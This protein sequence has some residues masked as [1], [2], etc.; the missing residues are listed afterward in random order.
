MVAPLPAYCA[1]RAS[2]LR[3]NRLSSCSW[4]RWILDIPVICYGLRADFM[5]R[6]FPGST[7][8][9]ELAHTIEETENHL[10]LR[11]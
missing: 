6:G 2:S 4:S 8:L 3:R 9:L 7:R 5:M 10:C 11:P 1:M